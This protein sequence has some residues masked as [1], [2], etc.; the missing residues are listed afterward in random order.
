M[1]FSMFFAAKEA[2]RA[3]SPNGKK[4]YYF[5]IILFS[6]NSTL[7]NRKRHTSIYVPYHEISNSSLNSTVSSSYFC[8]CAILSFTFSAPRPSRLKIRIIVFDTRATETALLTSFSC[9]NSW[10]LLFIAYNALSIYQYRIFCSRVA[11]SWICFQTRHPL[12][13]VEGRLSTLC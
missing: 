7:F 13:I 9:M 3:D 12:P 6:S 11:L 2:G 10:Y 4:D 1:Q 8:D 5:S